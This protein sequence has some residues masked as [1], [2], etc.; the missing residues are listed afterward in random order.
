MSYIAVRN[1]DKSIYG[2]FTTA[3]GAKKVLAKYSDSVF[4]V[5]VLSDLKNN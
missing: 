5:V 2:P 1:T 3:E 4:D